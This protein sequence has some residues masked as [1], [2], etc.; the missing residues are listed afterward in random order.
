MR[1][2]GVPTDIYKVIRN[3]LKIENGK[4]KVSVGEIDLLDLILLFLTE[5]IWVR[6]L[7]L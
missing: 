4:L 6:N 5:L 3:K 2:A 1:I 7:L